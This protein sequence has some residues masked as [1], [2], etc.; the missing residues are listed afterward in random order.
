M[1][2]DLLIK[3]YNEDWRKKFNEKGRLQLQQRAL[4]AFKNLFNNILHEPFEG[5]IVDVGCG[6]GALVEVFNQEDKINAKGIDINGGVN[7]ETDPLPY[8]DNEFDIAIMYSVIEHIYGP[9]NILSELKRVLRNGGLI[10]FVSPNLSLSN[11]II[12]DR[13]FFNDPT[14][15][16]PYNPVSIQH[17]MK[18]Y[19]YSERF[20]GLWTV[21][22]SAFIWKL[23]MQ[24]Q[25]YIGALLPFRGT[26][27]LVPSFLKGKSRTMLCVFEN[28]K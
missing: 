9:D 28:V 3:K 6:D 20:I 4:Y 21:R 1:K 16:H 5:N 23:P 7:F 15:V 8:K 17:L 25:F 11:L 18:L 12:C 27:S 26:V 19:N 13:G 24:L 10:V 22:K 14:H 2:K